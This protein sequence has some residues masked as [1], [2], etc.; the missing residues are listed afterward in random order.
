MSVNTIT[1]DLATQF[2]ITS[3]SST[4]VLAEDASITV[5]KGEGISN[6]FTNHDSTIN[7]DGHIT[8]QAFSM[9][10]VFSQGL[11]AKIDISETGT[12]DAY[13][14][15]SMSGAN[16]S[17]LNEGTITAANIGLYGKGY[18]LHLSNTGS[19]DAGFGVYVQ[20]ATDTTI[21]NTGTITGDVGIVIDNS[22]AKVTLGSSSV[23]DVQDTGLLFIGDR[24][25]TVE[26]SGLIESAAHA[27]TGS[28][29]AE[30]VINHGTIKGSIQLGDGNDYF[31][32]RGGTIDHAID[33]GAGN[34]TYILNSASD[35]V[36]DLSG[37]DMVATEFSASLN[38]YDTVEWLDLRGTGDFNASGNALVNGLYGNSGK[39]SLDGTGD[40]LVDTLA[41]DY[42][43]DTYVLGSEHDIVIELGKK[44][45]T[46][47]EMAD[48]IS[49]DGDI[50]TD[51]P[52][53]VL[54][55]PS[56]AQAISAE[57]AAIGGIDTITSTISRDLSD[58]AYIENLKLL[59]TGNINGT[60]NS[61]A[62]LITG[63]SGNNILNGG[64]ETKA[65]I[66]TLNGG[67]GNDTYVLGSG[68]DKIVDSAG[69]DMITSLISRNLST[70]ATIENLKLLGVANISG[71]GNALANTL[72]GNAGT[73]T[74]SGGAGN[75]VLIGGAG[76]DKLDGGANTDTA[77]YAGASAGVVANLSTTAS[78]TGDAKGDVYVSIENL[79][80]SSH[81][82]ML[83]GNTGINVLTGGTGA[84]KM[85][86]GAGAD[87][88]LF[89]VVDDSTMAVAGQ[90]TIYD[91]GH[92]QGD[93]IGLSGI[94]A[95]TA[96]SGDQAFVFKGTAAFS[97]TN[98]ELR[99]EKQAS[100][101]YVYGDTNG[102]KVADFVIH[103]DDAIAFQT[104]DFLF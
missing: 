31:D 70:F 104:S 40:G 51:L 16:S 21:D 8:A 1:S 93:R 59:G 6:Y 47:P 22:H 69:R 23:I 88:F 52:F 73:N 82:D 41:G 65:V 83:T 20:G 66:D 2:N 3:S 49:S 57:E 50:G 68:A 99:F 67:A 62:N 98:G 13:N 58:Y 37:N 32:N 48:E 89:K 54:N 39:N 81:N 63:N 103:F 24:S 33:G 60:G 27:I 74:L 79:T 76:A 34:D 43:D 91:F 18:N 53:E 55:D 92:A 86:G 19:I 78:N 35:K 75:D 29:A 26:N 97:G 94:D 17:V 28:A 10:G 45:D 95:N 36:V 42:G 71:T 64:V 100:D 101:T 46:L 25:S 102:D 72:T 11:T 90:D 96:I 80:G 38:S 87:T 12:I 85:T 30:T 5:V 15:V 56:P 4:W 7:V 84:D 14:G 44:A 9:S 77:S 61:L